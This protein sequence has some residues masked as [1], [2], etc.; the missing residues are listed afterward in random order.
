MVIETYEIYSKQLNQYNIKT[1]I[2]S[3]FIIKLLVN[4]SL[5]TE[6]TRAINFIYV[7]FK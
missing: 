7:T 3:K 2:N 5:E 4:L 1:V 6:I